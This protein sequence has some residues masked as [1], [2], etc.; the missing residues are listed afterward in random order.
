MVVRIV[1]GQNLDYYQL[2]P[3]MVCKGWPSQVAQDMITKKHNQQTQYQFDI[4]LSHPIN[5]CKLFL[6]LDFQI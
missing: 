4:N 5:S 6:H 2:F 3:N 1:D